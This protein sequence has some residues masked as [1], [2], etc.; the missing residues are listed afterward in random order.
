VIIVKRNDLNEIKQRGTPDFPLEMILVDADHPRYTMPFHWHSE[1]ELILVTEGE[2]HAVIGDETHCAVKG[3]ALFVNS[4]LVHGGT[5]KD[6][7]Y[8]CVIF[9]PS[10]LMGKGNL[11]WNGDIKRIA[12]VSDLAPCY[13][14]GGESDIPEL[15]SVLIKTLKREGKGSVLSA[16]GMIFTILGRVSSLCPEL[17]CYSQRQRLSGEDKLKAVLNYIDEHYSDSITLEEL[18]QV[19]KMNEG[20]F[21]EFFKRHTNRTPMDYLNTYRINMACGMLKMSGATVTETA[22]S[23][24]FNDLSYFIKTFKKYKGVTPRQYR[25]RLDL[26][27]L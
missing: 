21:C 10:M 12:D 25:R 6:S 24:G 11:S 9:D 19:A 3:D 23:C 22:F 8:Y 2:F 26:P 13:F 17:D 20:Y 14:K 18:S 7:S 1:F 4:G 5:P 16:L 15:M 27:N